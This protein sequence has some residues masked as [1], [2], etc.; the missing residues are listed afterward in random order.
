LYRGIKHLIAASRRGF[1][2]RGSAEGP[3]STA[4]A[5]GSR[6]AILLACFAVAGCVTAPPASR[7]S[8]N[9]REALAARVAFLA[10]PALKGRKPGTAGSRL[11]R[12]YMEER[13]KT[14]GLVPW[15]RTSGYELPFGLGVNVVGVLPGSD[16]KLA[17]EILLVSAHYDHLGK[18]GGKIHPGAADNASGVAAL[19]EIARRMSR[20]ERRQKR[21]VA[22]A[23]FDGEEQM[24][25]GSFAFTCRED[26]RRAKFA[27]V[28]NIDMLGRDFMD[29]V[30]NTVFVTGTEEYPALRERVRGFG[31]AAGMRTLPL[32]SYLVGPRGDFAAFESLGMPCLFFSCG[33]FRDYHRPTDTPDKLDYGEL[34]RSVSVMLQTAVELANADSLARAPIPVEGDLEELRTLTTVMAEALKAPEKAGIKSGDVPTFQGLEDRAE[35]LLRAGRYDRRTREELLMSAAGALLPY[36]GSA[37]EGRKPS[38][39]EHAPQE[40]LFIQ[41]A[42]RFYLNYRNEILDGYRRLVAQRLEY[43]PGAIRGMP[44]FEFGVFDIPDDDFSLAETRPGYFELNALV[45]Q[46]DLTV[47][48]KRTAWLV[49]S[50]TPDIGASVYALRCDGSRE[51]VADYCLLLFR[52]AQKRPERAAKLKK[53]FDQVSGTS[54]TGD[55]REL[56]V[57]RL[58]RGRFKDEIDWLTNCIV[59]GT[60]NLSQRAMQSARDLSDLRLRRAARQV[61]ADRK[62][63]PD[64]RAEAIRLV[65]KGPD[66]DGLLALCDAISDPSLVYNLEDDPMFQAG[67]PFANRTVVKTQRVL[68][69]T[70]LRDSPPWKALAKRTIGDMALE[71][72][73]KTAKMDLGKDPRSWRAWTEARVR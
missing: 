54:T 32:S 6:F 63:R 38:K 64:V 61:L 53:L 3:K 23:A 41:F 59:A 5:M 25:L 58:A 15:G 70:M 18:E 33:I 9:S 66:T 51:Q 21:P 24:L 55:Y 65:A 10:Q 34:D 37:E 35:N 30:T 69:E 52:D 43:R 40:T 46:F 27:A 60:T 19:L 49:N 26:V 50:A 7:D 47:E 2:S 29:V 68:L 45:N 4:R 17:N 36:M 73:R 48:V 31:A 14:S 20:L 71:K 11:A 42:V 16:P 13:F 72:L 62:R 12:R 56:L 8:G 39:V 1:F 57:A 44:K 67:S 28:I 22:F